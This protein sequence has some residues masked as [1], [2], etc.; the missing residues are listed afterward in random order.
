MHDVLYDS[1]VCAC[2]VHMYADDDVCVDG[3]V[4]IQT[5]VRLS[6]CRHACMYVFM[7]MCDHACMQS[8]ICLGMAAY[9]TACNTVR[10]CTYMCIGIHTI[11]G[12][13][14]LCRSKRVHVWACNPVYVYTCRHAVMC[15]VW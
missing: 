7:Y 4:N 3:G 2:E 6:V 15:E 1:H 8:L 10:M 9:R 11:H 5:H 14:Q 13:M 12:G